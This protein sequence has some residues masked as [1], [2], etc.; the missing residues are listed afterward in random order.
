MPEL[1]IVVPWR[2]GDPGRDRHWAKLKPWWAELGEV[3]EGRSPEGPFNRAWA[4]LDGAVRSKA[5]V[6][7]VVDADVVVDITTAVPFAAGGGWAMPHRF[8]T[9]LNRAGT[10]AFYDGQLASP[11]TSAHIEERHRGNPTGTCVVMHREALEAAPPDPRFVG[12]GHEDDAWQAALRSL[13]G[14][15]WKGHAELVHLWHEPQ[16]R[17]SRIFG[18]MENLRLL[19][20]YESVERSRVGM[21]RLVDEAL[22]IRGR[23]AAGPP[24]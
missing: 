20:R 9:R 5:E 16:E 10:D 3:I 7:V 18:S 17:R 15:V 1:S 19:R 11:V 23:I 21:R 13:V 14:D 12:W 2:P 4:I 24:W 6:L 8:V 22:P